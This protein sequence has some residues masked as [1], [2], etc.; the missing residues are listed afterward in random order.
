MPS[1]AIYVDRTLFLGRVEEQKQFRAV[2]NDVLAQPRNED[3]PY[4]LLLFGD[5]GMGKTT[6]A[7]RFR[8]IALT[9]QPFQGRFQVLWVDWEEERQ[10]SAALLS[11]REGISPEA[12]LD[13]IHAKAVN[14]EWGRHFAAYQDAIKKRG[15]AEKK[16]A[17]ALTV[18]GERDD[19]VA[20][21]GVSASAVAKVLRLSLPIGETGEKLAQAFLNVG[22]KVGVDQ[23]AHLRAV[24]E[25]R[26]RARLDSKQYDTFLEP[27]EQLARAFADGLKR[28]AANM[29]LIVF[30]DTYEIVDRADPWLRVVMHAAGARVIWV[31]SGRDNLVRSGPSEDGY[32]R[33]YAD[34]FPRRLL[35]FDIH[36]L[37][38]KDIRA[39]LVG[40]APRRAPDDATVRAIS[41]ATRGV[42]LALDEAAEMWAKGIALADI[43]GDTEDAIPRRQIVQKMT[44]R[45]LLHAVTE[46]DRQAVYALAMAH[47]DIE[48]L[49]A[50]LRPAEA[51][52]F[53]LDALLRR[54]ERDYAS[55]HY[56]HARLHDEP[57][58]FVRA[59]LRDEI[60]R[61]GDHVRALSQRAAEALRARLRR[62]QADLPRLEDRAE[63]D[64]WAR[65]A[66]DLAEYL[67][68]LDE[69]EAWHWIIPRF[70][71]SLA[72][73][74]ALRSGLTQT[75][76][77]W[78]DCLSGAGKK[79]VRIL[80]AVGEESPSLEARAALLEELTRLERLG[81][82]EEDGSAERVA[83]LD[84]QRGLLLFAHGKATEALAQYERAERALPEHGE[85]LGRHLGEAWYDLAGELLWPQ[86]AANA[87]P[88][89]DAERILPRVVAWLPEKQGAWYRLGVALGLR[90]KFCSAISAFQHASALDPKDA[91]P[92][93]GLGN[94]YY[95]LE[96]YDEA[97]AAYQ[98]AS[99]LDPK[100]AA[101]HNNIAGVYLH[102]RRFD[103]ARRE[104]N[105]RIRLGPEN[106]FNPLV[107]L[108]VI[109]RHQGLAESDEH[110]ARA[111]E[112]W[113]AAWRARWQTPA[114]LLEN[115][116]IALL[117]LDHKDEA[118]RVL[119]QAIA[120]MLPGDRIDF[121]LYTLLRAAPAPP[122]GLEEMIALLR[123]AQAHRQGA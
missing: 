48:I 74:Q 86:G 75:A 81:W 99:A 49:R 108:G 25:S 109:A 37:A 95:Q 119:R 76:V 118:L 13:A 88:S 67:F 19:L 38:E 28:I 72:Y 43:V 53:D 105:E 60:N 54:L 68:W 23:A 93:N 30:L 112:Q 31:V 92:H 7:K 40:R 65:A 29:P 78:C 116:S 71:E 96:R 41:R 27:H 84:W 33:G 111:L 34:D 51:V 55:V 106:T 22:I 52:T 9:E 123:E 85:T 89:A 113:G 62:M 50:M 66:L 11:G 117:C 69:S 44:A 90:S 26:L 42:P 8:N 3:L 2:L 80:R 61:T 20:L 102:Q 73:S 32:F 121:D 79:R 63:D 58:F 82:L 115:K 103:E 15:E 59:Y 17:A 24:V 4:V 14:A 87:L 114:G 120:Q 47:G 21:R 56:E 70:V 107:S 94:V 5:G 35:G 122:D 98:H 45:Y 6:L 16:A 39:L 77:H 91:Y 101:A 1:A 97:L 18:S 12:V 57:A 100:A 36:Q 64:D 104:L 46:Q 10:R 110:F 83:I